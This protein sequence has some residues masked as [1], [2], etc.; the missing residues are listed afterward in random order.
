MARGENMKKHYT[1]VVRAVL[2]RL[3]K[4]SSFPFFPAMHQVFISLRFA[5]S[6]KEAN[7]LKSA[8]EEK[9]ISTFL[10]AV[11]PGGD[12]RREIV[13]AL[14][15]CQ[16]AIIL[17]TK[18]YGKDTGV[19]Y[20][21]FEELRF[22]HGERKPFF[23][24]KMCERFEEP[25]TRFLLDSS[26]CFIKWFPGSQMPSDLI[27]KI[28]EKLTSTTVSVG[29]EQKENLGV[30]SQI[31][32]APTEILVDHGDVKIQA[33]IEAAPVTATVSSVCES[34]SVPVETDKSKKTDLM[35]E[36]QI[37]NAV[38]RIMAA[39]SQEVSPKAVEMEHSAQEKKK[40]NQ[41]EIKKKRVADALIVP[42][43][44][45]KQ[46]LVG[47]GEVGKTSLVKRLTS[48]TFSPIYDPTVG[49]EYASSNRVLHGKQVR[50][51]YW[52]TMGNP[53]FRT[54]TSENMFR[55][56]SAIYI[57]Y[58]VTDR[59][60]FNYV[61]DWHQRIQKNADPNVVI[62]LIGNKCDLEEERVVSFEEGLQ[63]A[64]QH[65]W[66]FFETSAK[67]NENFSLAVRVTTS[68]VLLTWYDPGNEFR[69]GMEEDIQQQF[70][71]SESK[72]KEKKEKSCILL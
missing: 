5:E 46:M 58:S 10:C 14:S 70:K 54:I 69:E 38:A 40:S 19:G 65:H 67:N 3:D 56:P 12:I 11:H 6:E 62:T 36:L 23:L 55:T 59:R 57:I 33:K 61:L 48:D 8:L 7:T 21:T 32:P 24:V 34:T 4:S 53:Q 72:E 15:S 13:N 9:G 68:L 35:P 71:N 51:Q 43:Y 26:V 28:V 49:V 18:T 20:S 39:I 52:D 30:L 42:D 25:E 41:K 44:V 47:H 29:L 1:T 2:N 17:G 27:T 22:I 45:I 37:Q 31:A 50:E 64:K 60:S 63:L 66:V 16:L